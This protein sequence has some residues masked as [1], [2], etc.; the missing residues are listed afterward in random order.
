MEELS[1]E[2][3]ENLISF[4]QSLANGT[5]QMSG[6]AL[7]AHYRRLGGKPYLPDLIDQLRLARQRQAEAP[8]K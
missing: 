5:N 8:Q 7:E 3:L 1:I 2:A 4:E 6:S